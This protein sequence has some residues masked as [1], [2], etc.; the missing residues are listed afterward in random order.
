MA[1]RRGDELNNLTLGVLITLLQWMTPAPVY[2]T[3]GAVWYAPMVMEANC[4]YR[5][6]DMEGFLDGVALMSPADLGKTVWI[7]GPMGWEGPFKSCDVGTRGQVWEMVLRRGELLELGWTTASRW[8]MGP[9]D[10]GWK[11]Q[12]EVFIGPTKPGAWVDWMTP[13]DYTSWFEELVK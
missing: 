8:G 11:R 1:A 9:F 13:V 3:G 4:E 12:V 10:G 2:S 6:Y 5:G 7:N